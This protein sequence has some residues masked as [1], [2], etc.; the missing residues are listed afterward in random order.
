MQTIFKLFVLYI[1]LPKN[2]QGDVMKKMGQIISE[3]LQ[4]TLGYRVFAVD[5]KG[6]S[7]SSPT[8]QVKHYF[9]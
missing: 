7:W 5:F 2:L 1:Y 3:L 4:R 6:I 9:L 8:I